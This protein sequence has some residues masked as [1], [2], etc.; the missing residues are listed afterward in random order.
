MNAHPTA[1]AAGTIDIGGDLTVNRMGFGAMRI[2][3]PASGASRLA[4]IR[5]SPR[6]GGWWNSA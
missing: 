4:R 3:G 2:T 1:A 6:S 5:P